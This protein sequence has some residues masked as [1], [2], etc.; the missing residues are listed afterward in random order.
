MDNGILRKDFLR[1]A[2]GLPLLLTGGGRL[3]PASA[4]S[5]SHNPPAPSAEELGKYYAKKRYDPAP[6]PQWQSVHP[7]LPAPIYEG[8]PDWIA[9]YWKSWE[10]AFR[11]FHE[12]ATGSGFVSQFIDAAFNANIFLWDSCFM[13]MFCNYAHPLVPG[14]GTLDNFYAKQHEDGEICRE[15]VRNTGVAFSQWV[16]RENRPLFSRWGK[17]PSTPFVPYDVVYRGRPAPKKNPKLTLDGLNHPI[18]AW[19][20]LESYRMTGDTARL[21]RIWEPLVHYYAALEEYLRQGNGLYMTDWASM[22]NSTRNAYLDRGGTGIDISSEMVL[23]ARQLSEIA[24]IQGTT[25]EASRFAS[26]A[27]RLAGV[28][29]Q[30]MWAP[31]RRFYFD[32]TLDGKPAPVKTIAAFWTLLAKVA[33]PDQ[34]EALAAEL[35]NPKTFKRLHRVPTLA[36]D[37]PGYNPAGGYWRGSVWAPTDT[38]VIRGLENYGY[39]ALAREIALNHLEVAAQ[40]FEKTGTIWENYAPDAATQG[41]PARQNFAG[42]SAIGPILYLMEYA[43]GLRADA[44]RNSLAWN[45]TPGIQHGCERYRFNGHVT[46]LVAKPLADRLGRFQVSVD[47]DGAF[48][49]SLAC[50]E[51]KKD[52]A[53]QS[54]RQAFRI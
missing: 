39:H 45:L 36:A 34:A 9:M 11:N 2:L 31:Q 28:I 49:L 13:T 43:I 4:Q 26:E 19:A 32:L 20:E 47:S 14:I 3:A 10:L 16:N 17:E 1:S 21:G 6:L 18:L 27:D 30:A 23:F 41:K 24:G 51:T 7:Q 44:P 52:F 46:S 40:V 5:D 12:P 25:A 35:E 29:N 48:T 38:M 22:D 15:I 37:E 50:G 33:S 53:V 42:W 54:G 8:R